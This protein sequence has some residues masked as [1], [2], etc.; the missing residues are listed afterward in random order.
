MMELRPIVYDNATGMILGGNMRYSAC[1][2][3]GTKEIPDTWVKDAADLTEDEKRRFIVEDNI[4]FGEWDFD[5]LSESFKVSD[6]KEWGLDV[7]FMEGS[8]SPRLEHDEVELTSYKMSHVLL[9]FPPDKFLLIQDHLEKIM[10][11]EGVEYE[12]SAN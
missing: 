5:L 3:L 10:K 4:P 8:T 7:D 11:I 12:Q 1:K 2:E 9:S 6:L